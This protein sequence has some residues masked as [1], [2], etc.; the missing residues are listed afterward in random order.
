ME[1]LLIAVGSEELTNALVE[2]LK[3]SREIR[4]CRDGNTALEL[5]NS[6][7][8]NQII[9]DLSLPLA[10]GLTVL[11]NAEYKPPMILALTVDN[12]AY[13]V[14]AARDVG[15]DFVMQIPCRTKAIVDHLENMIRIKA[16]DIPELDPQMVAGKHLRLL[17]ISNTR[18]GFRHLKVGIPLYCQDRGQS[19][20]KELYPAIAEVCGNDNGA[21]VETAIRNVIGDAWAHRNPLVWNEYFPG[22][23]K[24]PTNKQFISSLADK[25]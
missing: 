8:P 20:T 24:C 2:A 7:R 9:I 11:R 3:S 10:D 1:T 16:M 25:L 12:G 6:Y 19:M 5:L 14:Q 15:V 18:E 13:A 17:C 23:S 22:N 4:T 21:Q